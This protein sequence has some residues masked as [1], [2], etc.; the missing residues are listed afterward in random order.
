MDEWVDIVDD[1]DQVKGRATRAECHGNP[2]LM[3][4]VVHVL[5]TNSSGELLLQLRGRNKKIQPD[6]WDTSVGGHVSAGESYEE[7][8][9]REVA[10]EL[11][12]PSAGARQIYD[13]IWKSPIETERVRTYHLVH[14][15]DY[16][17]QAD[18][19][20][21]ARFWSLTE[22]EE[23]LGKD[24]FTPN[25]EQEWALFRKWKGQKE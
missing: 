4:R 23:N 11:G 6:K 10:E 13:Y 24:V 20:Q 7:A 18:E 25:F 1:A 19:I 15:G 16:R 9:D 5:V 22:I 3:H 2:A 14:D 21:E 12:I 17:I 8:L